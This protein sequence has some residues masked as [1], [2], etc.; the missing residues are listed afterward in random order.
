MILNNIYN[1]LNIPVQKADYFRYLAVY[2][3]GGTYSD[4]YVIPI[5]AIDKW[6]KNF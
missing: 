4:R 3:Y 6:L 2:Y 1:S 5:I